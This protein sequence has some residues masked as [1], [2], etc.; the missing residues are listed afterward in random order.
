M[1]VKKRRRHGPEEN[2][3]KYRDAD[4][5]LTAGKYQSAVLQS[6]EVSEATY[7]RWRNR[8]P[9]LYVGLAG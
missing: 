6:R 5:M 1:S 2:V 3:R 4:A 8:S 9:T 7:H